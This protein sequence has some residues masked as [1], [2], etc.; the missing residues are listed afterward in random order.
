MNND[1]NNDS[2][3]EIVAIHCFAV[4][5]FGYEGKRMEK[6]GGKHGRKCGIFRRQHERE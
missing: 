4:P 3:E 2:A 6:E 5:R 1:N